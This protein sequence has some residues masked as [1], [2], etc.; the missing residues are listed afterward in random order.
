MLPRTFLALLATVLLLAATPGRAMDILLFSRLNI[1]DQAEYVSELVVGA[2]KMLRA[3][4]HPDQ[5][6]RAIALF[7]DPSPNGGVHQMAEN[8]K[9][10]QEKNLRIQDNPNS[11][12]PPYD[13][14]S[15]MVITLK[16][17]GID[18]PQNYLETINRH[19]T[20][21]YPMH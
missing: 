15:A 17:A 11:H 19:F 10:L 6:Q 18:V 20:P 13:V 5:A 9:E 8:L 12:Q 16:H 7:K 4:G 21:F 14:E 3:Q 2:A 1:D